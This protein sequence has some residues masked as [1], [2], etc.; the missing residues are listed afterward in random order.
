MEVGR[1]EVGSFIIVAGALMGIDHIINA[2]EAYDWLKSRS[3][4]LQS[5]GET[6]RFMNDLAGFEVH[7]HE[8]FFISSCLR[9]MKTPCIF[10]H[11]LHESI[12]FSRFVNVQY[13]MFKVVRVSSPNYMRVI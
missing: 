1:D 12:F 7:S 13:V 8:H 3:K 4:L 5:L 6:C 11:G 2:E 10:F 9:D